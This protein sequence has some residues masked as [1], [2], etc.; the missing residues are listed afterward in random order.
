MAVTGDGAADYLLTASTFTPITSA[1]TWAFWYFPLGAPVNGAPAKHAFS[2]TNSTGASPNGYDV[3]FA[4]DH[5]NANTYKAAVHR[6]D[7]GSFALAQHP[8]TP[9]SAAWHHVAAVFNGSTLKLYYDGLEVASVAASAPPA[10]DGSPELTVLAYDGG[11]GASAFDTGSIGNLAIWNTNLTAAQI[12]LL[13]QGYAATG[14]ALANLVSYNP[15]NSGDITSIGNALT[16]NGAAINTAY[17]FGMDGGVVLGADF[18]STIDY[19][20]TMSGGIVLGSGT[21]VQ[22]E[23]D[24]STSFALD[25]NSA[26]VPVARDTMALAATMT[27]PHNFGRLSEGMRFA[28]RFRPKTGQVLANGRSKGQTSR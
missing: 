26:D 28:T 4:W 23:V 3:N 2:F 20:W 14:I 9:G 13:R 22:S 24:F 18:T 6:N 8:G 25:D 11:T 7:D 1:Y 12:M 15:L 21:E 5:P 10:G 17:F 27:T 19:T 16:N